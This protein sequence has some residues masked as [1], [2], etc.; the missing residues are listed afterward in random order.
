MSLYE[1]TKESK[2][3]LDQVMELGG[4]ITE[5]QESR[6]E[7]IDKMLKEKASNVC[8]YRKSLTDMQNAVE[9]R[10][11]DLK[12][13]NKIIQNK[14]DRLDSYV[15]GCMETS[16]ITSI[17]SEIWSIKLRKPSEIVVITDE[18]KIPLEFL[19]TK[20]ETT[21]DKAEIKKRLKNKEVIEGAELGLGKVSVIYKEGGI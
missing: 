17:E 10:I 2:E 14:I 20:T 21:I 5:S 16:K 18:D 12:I 11:D 19:K 1:I 3:L 9:Q 8:E 15:L 6:M 7:S 13:S 4:E